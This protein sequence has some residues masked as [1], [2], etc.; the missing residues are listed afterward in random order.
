VYTSI[1]AP[2]G[3]SPSPLR[4]GSKEEHL[5]GEV[6]EGNALVDLVHVDMANTL[7]H[8]HQ[9]P[10]SVVV[11][12]GRPSRPPVCLAVHVSGVSRVA[13]V[14]CGGWGTSLAGLFVGQVCCTCAYNSL[15][16]LA[17][18]AAVHVVHVELT[19]GAPEGW[20]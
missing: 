3:L 4:G 6:A 20:T 8:V 2:Q 1:N 9:Q 5:G 13:F 10:H 11:S 12:K 14:G 18:I 15:F 17:S 19:G 7:I 16:C